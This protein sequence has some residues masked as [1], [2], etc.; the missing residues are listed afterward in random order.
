MDILFVA[1]QLARDPRR[2][3]LIMIY[4]PR[5]RR[6]NVEI[7]SGGYVVILPASPDEPA[8][9]NPAEPTGDDNIEEPNFTKNCQANLSHVGTYFEIPNLSQMTTDSKS[10]SCD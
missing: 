3:S 2:Q 4:S 6:A 5:S 10:S 8:S 1:C 7:P 9:A